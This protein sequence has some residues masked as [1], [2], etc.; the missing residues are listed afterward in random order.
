M[1][2]DDQTTTPSLFPDSETCRPHT[3][4]MF[5]KTHKTA[6]STVLNVI[7]RFGELHELRF[8]LPNLT[9]LLGYPD[10]FKAELVKGYRGPRVSTFNIMA[11]HLRFNLP[12]VCSWTFPPSF[13]F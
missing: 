3:N 12:E 8:A 10:N 11:N 2:N 1:F 5:L 4:I 6:S 9:Y 7:Y 13:M